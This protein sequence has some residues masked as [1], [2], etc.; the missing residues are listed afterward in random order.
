MTTTPTTTD[1]K[2]RRA[3]KPVYVPDDPFLT[4][5]KAAAELGIGISTVWAAV[6]SGRLPAPTYVTPRCP[7]WRRSSL[8]AAVN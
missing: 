4:A 3:E 1:P 8:R 2:P 6:K 5:K 7:R